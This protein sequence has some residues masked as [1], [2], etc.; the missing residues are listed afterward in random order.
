MTGRFP[1]I[2]VVIVAAGSGTR[3]ASGTPKVLLPLGGVP[4][5][6][7]SVRTALGLDGVH[8]L[9]LVVRPEDREDVSSAATPYLGTHDAWLVDGG[10]ER[11][12]SE[13]AALSALAADIDD[14]ELD[15]VI[16]HDGARPLAPADLWERVARAAGKGGAVPILEP[17]GLATTGGQ[18][19]PGLA[20]VQ[21]PQAFAAGPL[22]AAYRAADVDGFTGTDTAA[23]LTRYADLPV[24]GVAGSPVNLK[25][26]FPEDLETAE[27]LLTRAG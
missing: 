10:S 23:C 1:R 26:T 18:A 14:G 15:L 8:R 6:V 7:H 27:R 16:V 3:M 13:W 21:T 4:V 25:I 24:A 22:L 11:H 19:A 20:T 17:A 2:G 5:L 12:D 9:V